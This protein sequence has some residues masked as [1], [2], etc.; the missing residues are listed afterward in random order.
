MKTKRGFTLIE[1]MIVV[2]ILALLSAIA[3]PGLL[4]SQRAANERNAGG[5]MKTIATAQAD[6]RS[7]DRD[8][9]GAR[10]FW[11]GDVA[12]LYAIDNTSTGSATPSAIKLIEG[13]VAL[14]DMI[15]MPGSL[16]NGNYANDISTF[17]VRSSKAGYWYG[18]LME[19]LQ[20]TADGGDGVYRQDTDGTGDLVHNSS[21]FAVAAIPESYGASGNRV[22]L[23]NEGNTMFSRD[24]GTDVVTAGTIPPTPTGAYDGNWPLD[25]TLAGLWAKLD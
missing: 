25:A 1:L 11:T 22:F 9:N 2:A 15:T 4:N 14:G 21:R 8:N 20:V 23:I 24:F 12:G 18:A 17:G 6:F 13:S 3:I 10:D 16:S 19:D 5:S 7:N